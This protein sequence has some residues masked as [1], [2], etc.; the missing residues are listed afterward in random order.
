MSS[1]I[2]LS[3]GQQ[4]WMSIVTG[5]VIE[6]SKSSVTLNRPGFRGGSNCREWSHEEVPEVFP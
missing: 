6:S 1:T 2:T 3:N 5:E 4:I